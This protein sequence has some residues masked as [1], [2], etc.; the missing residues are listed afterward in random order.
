EERR[1]IEVDDAAEVSNVPAEP[2]PLLVSV[3]VLA[4][5]LRQVAARALEDL[6]AA[7]VEVVELPP[8]LR[9]IAAV[10]PP[11]SPARLLWD[12]VFHAGGRCRVSRRIIGR[13]RTSQVI[14]SASTRSSWA[15]CAARATPSGPTMKESCCFTSAAS[16]VE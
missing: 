10:L 7:A 12:T 9:R 11:G 1:C 2:E 15:P 14:A 5:V 8:E 13:Q 4:E 6:V 3:R 16:G